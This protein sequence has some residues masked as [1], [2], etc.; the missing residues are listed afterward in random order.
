MNWR[1]N[2]WT[3]PYPFGIANIRA[4][5]M[6]DI[7]EAVVNSTT[8]RRRYAKSHVCVRA[9]Q[10]GPYVRDESVRIILAISGDPDLRYRWAEIDRGRSGTN[11]GEFYNIIDRI[12]AFLNQNQ[13]GRIFTFILDNLNIHH[14]PMILYLIRLRGHRVVFRAPYRP[15]DG[16]IEYVFNTIENAL[17]LAVHSIN[18]V[19]DIIR[20]L[21]SIIRSLPEFSSYFYHCGYRG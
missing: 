6:I 12:T 21:A 10:I 9:R 11:L 2:Y 8:A 17:T 15:Q 7:D 20:Q 19:H 18:N 3:L 14:N 16:P 4:C 1:R 13:P 5:D